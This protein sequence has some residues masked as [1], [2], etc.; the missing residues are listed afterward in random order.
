[1][2]LMFGLGVGSTYSTTAGA[3][4][5]GEYNSA[6]GATSVIGTLN[7]T[8]QVTGVQLEKGSTATSF[9]YIPYTTELQLA[10]RFYERSAAD[11]LFSG[12]VTSGGDY[13]YFVTYKVTK[14]A[15]ATVTP[16][17]AL[18]L[19]FPATASTVNQNNVD[20]FQLYRS[21]NATARGYFF[22]AWTASAEL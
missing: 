7:A 12:N 3:W 4:A 6:T 8:W 13:F 1:M 18:A 9:D 10:Q 11:T 20:G 15:V 5:S 2:Q 17:N 21:A 16:T 19:S 14:R 22:D